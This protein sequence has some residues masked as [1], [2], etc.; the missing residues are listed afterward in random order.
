MGVGIIFCIGGV[1]GEMS[2]TSRP[3]F[4]VSKLVLGIALGHFLTIG[5]MYCSEVSIA[6]LLIIMHVLTSS[7][8]P[9]LFSVE[10]Q[11]P[12]STWALPAANYSQT[13]L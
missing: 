13:L 8:Y 10:L 5:P 4:L 3:A 9:Q 11:L 7:S 12:V 1:A 6:P 2:S